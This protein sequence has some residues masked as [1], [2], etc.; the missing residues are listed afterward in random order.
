MRIIT[1]NTISLFC[2]SHPMAFK[3]LVFWYDAVKRARWHNFADV[4]QSFPTVS[5]VGN[6][7][8]VFN[9]LHN[10]YRLIAKIQFTDQCVYIRFIGTHKTYDRIKDIQNI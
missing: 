3:A 10:E 1:K 9:I 4:K 6:Q 5:Q 8:Y 2:K 7:R